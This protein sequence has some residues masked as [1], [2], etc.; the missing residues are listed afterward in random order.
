MKTLTTVMILTVGVLFI[1]VAWAQQYD[2]QNMPQQQPY[3]MMGYGMMGQGMMG[4][5]GMM[6]NG[7]MGYGGMM[8]NMMGSGTVGNPDFY[9]RYADELGL[10]DNQV[11]RLRDIRMNFVRET[12]DNRSNLQVAWIELQDIL[13]TENVS[14][15]MAETKIRDIHDLQAEIQIEAVRSNIEARNILTPEQREEARNVLR[16]RGMY[17]GTGSGTDYRSRRGGSSR[18]M[19]R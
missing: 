8:G 11:T 5:S 4:H 17:G 19:M 12:A 2:D 13:D 9:L 6:G 15:G 14:I 1:A 3:G 16:S 10:N 7:M 18:G